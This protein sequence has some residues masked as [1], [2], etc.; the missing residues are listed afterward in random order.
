MK[1][2]GDLA[3]LAIL[4]L[5]LFI[6]LTPE[7]F[8]IYGETIYSGSVEDGK[9]ADAGGISFTF[10]VEPVSSKVYVEFNSSG[11][12][13]GVIVPSFECRAKGAFNICAKNISFAYRN[14]NESRDVY[15]A[16]IEID[17]IKSKIEVSHSIGKQS[18]L[19]DEETTAELTVQNTADISAKEFVAT[20]EIPSNLF[21]GEVEGCRKLYNKVILADEI[22]PAEIKTC[23]YRLT[24]LAPGDF[25]L[26]PEISF[27][28]GIGTI[29]ATSE[30][31][32]GKV[33]NRSLK[34][35]PLLNKSSFDIGEKFNLTLNIENTNEEYDLGISLMNLK[36][37]ANLLL[38]KQPKE[39]SKNNN[40]LTWS[41][42]LAPEEA[43]SFIME[44]Q[45]YATGNYSII[46]ESV[47]KEGKFSRRSEDK[48]GIE[49]YCD[50]PAI[51]HEL[52]PESFEA[53]QPVRLAARLSNPNSVQEFSNVG[54]SYKSSIP[55]IKSGS[56]NYGKISPLEVIDI[57]SS[58]FAAPPPGQVYE[59]N[60]TAK[61]SSIKQPFILRKN[62]VIAPL[63]SAAEAQ[64]KQSQPDETSPIGP[65][66][67]EEADKPEGAKEA[68]ESEPNALESG[69]RNAADVPE[70]AQEITRESVL[71]L[72]SGSSSVKKY[73]LL[74]AIALL[75]IVLTAAF[76]IRKRK[77]S[78][79][80]AKDEALHEKG[81]KQAAI[82]S[83]HPEKDKNLQVSEEK[84]ERRGLKEIIGLINLP[85][86]SRAEIKSVGNAPVGN[87]AEKAAAG[88]K[89]IKTLEE[90]IQK[91]GNIFEKK[92]E[93]KGL[94]GKFFKKK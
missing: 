72:S 73:L 17:V 87:L 83:K 63:S 68:E 91:M 64:Q 88:N 14:S 27:F 41:G 40:I 92:K 4:V 34:I 66:S 50:C 6:A 22:T 28:D 67:G 79:N 51:Q 13:S 15:K 38:V 20:I 12:L 69:A 18:L 56:F 46:A 89:E 30:S 52:A 35:S 2:R 94:F 82:K 1:K 86:R 47:Y 21:L 78:S 23:S 49:I 36:L 25:E 11:I 65:K 37:P 53:L 43:A 84:K 85:W 81:I 39:L 29:N 55:S 45:S 10:R 57:I 44:L 93:E 60:I 19:L 54:I 48:L 74:A 5:S 33:Y 16:D 24:G 3:V 31:A 62:I 8:S 26:N 80:G 77:A 32:Q 7:A 9:T 76:I 58:S 75:L 59:L 70:E 90:E 71:E 61:F 42:S